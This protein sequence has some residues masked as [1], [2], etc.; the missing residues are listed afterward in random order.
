MTDQSTLLD[1]INQVVLSTPV[2]DI[3][4]HLF[5]PAF[6]NLL[7][8]GIDEMLVYHYLVAEGFRHLSIPYK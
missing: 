7:L 1:H 8:W 2:Y 6:G 3:H 4:T 5:D